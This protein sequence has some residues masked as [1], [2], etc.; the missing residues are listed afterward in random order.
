MQIEPSEAQIVVS[1]LA[2]EIFRDRVSLDQ[3][4]SVE[5]SPDRVDT[6]LWRSLADAGLLAVC[7]AE[8]VGGQ[9]GGLPVLAAL[10][11]TQG[12]FVAPVPLASTLVSAMAVD[13]FASAD[14]RTRLL[15]EVGSG[16]LFLTA[17]LSSAGTSAWPAVHV[18]QVGRRTLLDGTELAVSAA[19]LAAWLL[20]P[21]VDEAGELGLYLTS[22]G[23][24]GVSVTAVA[25]T[26]RQSAGHVHLA[27]AAGQRLGGFDAVSWLVR[28]LT[29]A[30]CAVQYGV[31]RTAVDLTARY[32]SEREQ[33]GKPLSY[34]QAVLMRIAD[35]YI[36]TEAMHVTVQD[37]VSE[38]AGGGNAADETAVAKWW[39]S[40]GGIQAVEA[41]VHLH[42]GAGYLLDYVLSRHTLW[43][44]QIDLMLG[45]ANYQLQEL[46]NRIADVV[47]AGESDRQEA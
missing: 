9:D 29:V 38:L 47:P 2:E 44:K 27:G 7:L 3:L 16:K 17:A 18:R 46:G 13:R 34:F 25:T 31:A 19:P 33:F 26:D 43:A 42:G 1:K 24:E 8:D 35:A 12:R 21:A 30:L 28:H 45:S 15:P 37:A 20:V 22:S 14:V 36:A 39:A 10:L 41:A 40:Q 32:I 4:V 5:Q 11:E 23:T 6:V